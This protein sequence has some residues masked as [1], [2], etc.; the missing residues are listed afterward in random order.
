MSST[1]KHNV[2]EESTLVRDR[3]HVGWEV[4]HEVLISNKLR[5]VKL[6]PSEDCKAFRALAPPQR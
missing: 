1:I 4:K 6:S 5:K 3:Y 2:N